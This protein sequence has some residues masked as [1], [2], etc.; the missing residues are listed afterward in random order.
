MDLVRKDIRSY[1]FFL[2]IYWGPYLCYYDI[3]NNVNNGS[4]NIA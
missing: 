2:Y 4:T 3:N 1:H